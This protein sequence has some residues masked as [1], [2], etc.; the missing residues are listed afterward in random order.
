MK[1][2]IFLM[3]SIFSLIA[4]NNGK[5]KGEYIQS[6]TYINS[7]LNEYAKDYGEISIEIANI[8]MDDFTRIKTYRL[9]NQSKILKLENKATNII[10]EIDK[11]HNTMGY[12][13]KNMDKIFESMR[14]IL[15]EGLYNTKYEI[16]ESI[17]VDR[18]STIAQEQLKYMQQYNINLRSILN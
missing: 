11:L 16:S 9:R 8:A 17:Y 2:A 3:F 15:M 13:S 4:C 7:L 18:E 14:H 10:S 12:K 6:V 5:D 1:R